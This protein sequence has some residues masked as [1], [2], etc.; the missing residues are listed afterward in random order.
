[1]ARR[2]VLY[3]AHERR[4]AAESRGLERINN[5]SV[6]E[7]A[8]FEGEI[9][10]LREQI[11]RLEKQLGDS[12]VRKRTNLVSNLPAG[13]IFLP[14]LL[15]HFLPGGNHPRGGREEGIEEEEYIH[16]RRTALTGPP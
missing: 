12:Q 13:C 14:L 2:A 8:K 4:A 11:A 3:A 10:S 9:E 7:A 16:A 1:M 15:P 5:A 6:K